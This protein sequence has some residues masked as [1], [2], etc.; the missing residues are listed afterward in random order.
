MQKKIAEE[1]TKKKVLVICNTVK[2]A[3]NLY[4]KINNIS[5]NVRLLHSLYIQ[6]DRFA[7][8]NEIK[9]FSQSDEPEPG[10]WITTQ[11]V[12]ASWT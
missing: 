12:E 5:S 11:L 6:R 7:L 1:G 3:V 9:E 8:E 10:I 4:L 2:Q